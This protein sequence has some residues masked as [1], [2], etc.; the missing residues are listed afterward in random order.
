MGCSVVGQAYLEQNIPLAMNLTQTLTNSKASKYFIPVGIGARSA[1]GLISTD[2]SKVQKVFLYLVGLAVNNYAGSNA[3][4]CSP[5]FDNQWQANH[6]DSGFTDLPTGDEQPDGQMHDN[7]W[8]CP[9]EG[10]N[11]GFSLLFDVTSLITNIDGTI[12]LRLK[13]GRSKQASLVV[14]L[15]AYLKILWKL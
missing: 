4:Y 6:E 7:D 15:S 14:T 11:F 13:D 12:G 5:P 3:L 2:D 1:Q 10:A 9:V 8:L